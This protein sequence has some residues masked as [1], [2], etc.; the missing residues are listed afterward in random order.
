MF[1][2]FTYVV[3]CGDKIVSYSLSFL[4]ES[5]S[6]LSV[7]KQ[8]GLPESVKIRYLHKPQEIGSTVDPY[9]DSYN[10]Q[11]SLLPIVKYSEICEFIGN[12]TIDG[13]DPQ[14]A[15][16]SLDRFHTVCS[17]G[18]MGNLSVKKM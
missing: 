17:D 15:F 10:D 18:W 7:V 8:Q 11:L 13:S 4:Q 6:F 5:V 3:L 16:K 2:W 14:K 12:H 9:V 1:I